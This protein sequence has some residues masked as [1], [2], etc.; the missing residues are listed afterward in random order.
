[1]NKIGIIAGEGEL[2]IIASKNAK[3][4]GFDVFA[5]CFEGFTSNEIE[6]YSKAE[7]FKLG[8]V[9][10]P[11]RFLKNNGV[12]KV[13][14]LGKIEHL[15]LFRD[16]RPDLRTIKMIY[17]MRKDARPMSVFRVIDEELKKEGIEVVDST[18][19]LKE[20]LAPKGFI[21]GKIDEDEIKEIEYGYLIAKKIADMDIGLSITIKNYSVI[22]VEGIDG[23]D[24]CIKRTGLILKGK[25]FTLVKVGR[26]NQDMR[27]D[28]P[29]IGVNTVLNM[30][31]AH[32]DII[33]VE[34]GKTVI[35]DLKKTIDVAIENGIKIFGI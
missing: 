28:L 9:I 35:V 8:S 17:K 33:A 13:I 7:F 22:S 6:K 14:L 12:D 11:L 1:M 32:G 30:K 25:P 21:A 24:E 2:P 3:K 27:F 29:V 15:N 19:F 20:L 4:L 16:I 10:K 18:I 5:V 23:T 34:S 26:S 31:N